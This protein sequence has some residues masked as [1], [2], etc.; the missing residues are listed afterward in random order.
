MKK[1]IFSF[2]HTADLHL[3]VRPRSNRQRKLDV[4]NSYLSMCQDMVDNRVNAVLMAGDVLHSKIVD[5]ETQKALLDGF[6]ILKYSGDGTDEW[7]ENPEIVAITGNHCH[8]PGYHWIDF[9]SGH[10]V[11]QAET[12]PLKLR[13]FDR[14]AIFGVNWGTIKETKA[15]I[16]QMKPDPRDFNILMVHQAA[17]GHIFGESHLSLEYINEL[18]KTFKYVA[19]GHIHHSYIIDD[20]AFNPGSIEYLSTTDWDSRTGFF[21]VD[22]YDDFTFKYQLVETKKRPTHNL[23]ISTNSMK[24]IDKNEIMSIIRGYD[25]AQRSMIAV[26]IVGDQEVSNALSKELER[27]LIRL[28]QAVFVRIRNQTGTYK[29]QPAERIA[30]DDLYDTA[31]ENSVVANLAR[32]IEKV[33][34]TEPEKVISIVKS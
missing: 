8:N 25:I 4:F 9:H 17:E 21:L 32:E 18:G 13:G 33:Y 28:Y 30:N 10:Y 26:D 15:A 29:P 11:H 34:R 16:A 12:K 22:V 3:G 6:D 23:K 1:T 20:I 27:D 31:F 24:A 5:W 2:A 19:L 7:F 14:V